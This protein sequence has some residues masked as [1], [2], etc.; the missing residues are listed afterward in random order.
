MTS[1]PLLSPSTSSIAQQQSEA[2]PEARK[3]AATEQGADSTTTLETLDQRLLTRASTLSWLQKPASG[4]GT[5]SRPISAVQRASSPHGHPTSTP[6]QTKDLSR[7]QISQNLAAKDPSWFRQSSERP[8]TTA[9]FRRNLEDTEGVHTAQ[10]RALPGMGRSVASVMHETATDEGRGIPLPSAKSDFAPASSTPVE[11]DILPVKSR[12]GEIISKTSL[13]PP[14]LQGSAPNTAS[15]SISPTKGLGGFVQSAIKRSDSVSKRWSVQT[16]S[17]LSRQGSNASLRD[18]LANSAQHTG[19]HAVSDTQLKSDV[20]GSERKTTTLYTPSKLAANGAVPGVERTLRHA[21]SESFSL[22]TNVGDINTDETTAPTS[23]SRRWSP[24][25]S[26]WLESALS[27]PS[28][29]QSTSASPQPAWL[30]ELNKTKQQ[31][32]SADITKQDMGA[33]RNANDLSTS[34]SASVKNPPVKPK[35][36]SVRGKPADFN[37]TETKPIIGSAE[38]SQPP[39]I[40][41]VER[42]E[43]KPVPPILK[44]KPTPQVVPKL[45]FRSNLKNSTA[46]PESPQGEELEFRNAFGKLKRTHAEKYVP[47]DELKENILR[48]KR[49]LSPTKGPQT[50]SR[51]DE[52]KE[53]LIEQRQKLVPKTL[54]AASTLSSLKPAAAPVQIEEEEER[55]NLPLRHARTFPSSDGTSDVMPTNA[56]Q[57]NLAAVLARSATS[58]NRAQ[59]PSVMASHAPSGSDKSSEQSSAP[60][61]H[62]TKGRA[63]GPKRRLPNASGAVSTPD[64]DSSPGTKKPTPRA[65]SASLR[66]VPPSQIPPET[67]DSPVSMPDTPWKASTKADHDKSPDAHARPLLPPRIRSFQGDGLQRSPSLPSRPSK[68]SG[69]RSTSG[70]VSNSAEKRSSPQKHIVPDEF[71]SGPPSVKEASAQWGRRNVSRDSTDASDNLLAKSPSMQDEKLNSPNSSLR[72]AGTVSGG[73]VNRATIAERPTAAGA[74]P[75]PANRRPLPPAVGRKPSADVNEASSAGSPTTRTLAADQ[76]ARKAIAEFFADTTTSIGALDLGTQA[77]VDAHSVDTPK[78]KTLRK[79]IAELT[80]DGQT[81]SLPLQQDHVLYNR[82]CYVCSHI[83]GDATGARV[84]EVYLWAGSA[85]P[86][87]AFDE[88]QAHARQIARNAGGKLQVFRQG[89]ESSNFFQALGGIL[90]TRYGTTKDDK[91]SYMLCGRRHLGHIAFDEV[92][93]S[94]TNLCSAYPFILSSASTNTVYLWKGAGCHSEELAGARLMS[95]DLG[96]NSTVIEVDEGKETKDFLATFPASTEGG[97]YHDTLWKHKA[98]NQS[99]HVRLFR[100]DYSGQQDSAVTSLW[101][102]VRQPAQNNNTDKSSAQIS[103]VSP[104]C[105]TDVE[106]ENVYVLDA[107]FEVYV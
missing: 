53:S 104:F 100:I 94:I 103:E 29:P 88:A 14:S 45:D 91:K 8:E 25:K 59:S 28:S 44:P 60:L 85:V 34:D 71:Q 57:S 39:T 35:P 82:N 65:K 6:P 70:T 4:L 31:R 5:R 26:T 81:N 40:S 84:T 19:D 90:I 48:G 96:L 12:S 2:R 92:E 64:V 63:R 101:N 76:G 32:Y 95:M 86:D 106:P 99:Y 61:E 37:L 49:D 105:E 42:K 87:S 102:R 97:S 20:G 77:I 50:N 46:P 69:L 43:D 3:Q 11:Q 68:P 30:S 16:Q 27:R 15:R 80:S 21:R 13:E 18:G 93:L 66:Q 75:I 22:R 9:A 89:K 67:E 78:I 62:M 1:P 55:P 73:T 33:R 51:K 98:T 41:R 107:F 52:L 47:P 79:E 23:P 58:G 24:V 36:M 83:F 17:G 56:F 72:R 74:S 10:R 38:L 54:G 7:D